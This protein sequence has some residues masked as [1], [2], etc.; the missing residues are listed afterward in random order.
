M[1]P[2]SQHSFRFKDRIMPRILLLTAGLAAGI[3][4]NS[5]CGDRTK[6]PETRTPETRSTDPRAS[7]PK[8]V[9]SSSDKTSSDKTSSDKT[10]SDKTREEIPPTSK[11]AQL[12]ET[13][14]AV[15]MANTKVGSIHTVFET[16]QRNGDTMIKASS[17]QKLKI[18]RADQSVAM[19]TRIESMETEEG[20]LRSFTLESSLGGMPRTV[21]GTYRNGALHLVTTGRG[22]AERTTLPWSDDHGGFF[23]LEQSFDQQPMKPGEEREL[24]MLMPGVVGVQPVTTRLRAQSPE[25]V[26][27]LDGSSRRLLKI[28]M[29]SQMGNQE[30]ESFCW[31]SPDGT[32]LKTTI[33]ALQQTIYRTTQ[34]TAEA[35][36]SQEYD[37]FWDSIVRV[38]PP[39]PHPHELAHAKY[40]ISLTEKDPANL[41]ASGGSQR[42]RS[43]APRKAEIT[44][45]AVRPDSEP[46][47]AQAEAPAPETLAPNSLIQA[48]DPQ[49]VKMAQDLVDPKSERWAKCVALEKGV[50]EAIQDKNF[51]QGF[52]TAADVARSLEGDCTEHAVLLAA[53][54]RAESIPARI[55]LGLV[56]SPSDQGFAFHMW[57]EAWVNERW[58]PLD[59]TLGRGGIGAAHLKLRH[60]TLASED[61][62]SAI[63]SVVQVIHQLEIKVLDFQPR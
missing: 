49:V 39:L 54:C 14:E 36:G 28:A 53:L 22:N 8:R 56:Y 40:E 60:S 25:R 12:R 59:A 7:G 30:L 9:V 50:H 61:A 1:T 26:D 20:A 58:T 42:V 15:Y 46:P 47:E 43:I 41:F 5:G 51:G 57:T 37:L 55:A 18:K 19:E 63:L 31:T 48:D 6:T 13:W 35:A 21:T 3:L 32:V 24:T 10:S 17:V 33:P 4:L 44:V 29:N 38:T 23:A 52:A 16:V 2:K 11:A 34:D 27:L 62:E 45:R